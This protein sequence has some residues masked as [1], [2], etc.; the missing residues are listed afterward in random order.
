[1]E[2]TIKNRPLSLR[3][4]YLPVEQSTCD[5]RRKRKV[6]S[7]TIELVIGIKVMVTS[8]IATDLDITNGVRGTDI[9]IILNPEEPPLGMP[10]LLN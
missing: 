1:M 3:E 8:N 5:G 10:P 2:D 4:R 9:D 7:E 6:L